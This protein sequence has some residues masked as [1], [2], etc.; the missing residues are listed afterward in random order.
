MATNPNNMP[1]LDS[2][3]ARNAAPL[4]ISRKQSVQRLQVGFAG[5]AV[6]ILLVGLANIVIDQAQQTQSTAVPEA[7]PTVAP[8]DISQ[9]SDPLADAGV[10]PDLP[11]EKPKDVSP[12]PNMLPESGD[13]EPTQIIP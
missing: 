4:D 7:A 9:G 2:K 1:G 12:E 6:M 5:L 13:V 10:V 8:K 11:A 3:G